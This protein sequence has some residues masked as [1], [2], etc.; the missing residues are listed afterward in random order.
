MEQF[1]SLVGNFLNTYGLAAIFV[2]ML[3]KEV[4]VPIPVPSDI[5]MITAGVQAAAGVYSV[6]ELLILLEVA[7]LVGGS[8][9]FLIARSGGRQVI[10]RFGRYVGLTRERLDKAMGLLQR[11]GV[12]AVFLGLNVPGARAG[13]IPAAGL[14]GL[15]YT[16]FTP[17][18]LG[19]STLFY[20]WHIALGYLVGPS[21]TSLLENLHLPV[22]P[23]VVGLILVGLIGWLILRRRRP[24]DPGAPD[25]TMDRLHSWTDAACP[26]CLTIAAVQR[27]SEAAAVKVETT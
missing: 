17:A 8:A 26:A 12:A 22:F 9:Q 5:I 6:I 15:A 11:R 4:G 20:G 14:A 1:S 3:L 24:A 13:I 16:A 18:M 25:S 10:Y 21:A 27:L 2:V 23:I 19:G 7:M